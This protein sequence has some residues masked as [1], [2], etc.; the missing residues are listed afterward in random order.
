[1]SAG[2][3]SSPR[4]ARNCRQSVFRRRNLEE[5]PLDLGEKRLGEAFELRRAQP[6]PIANIELQDGLLRNQCDG[7]D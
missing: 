6:D 5:L 7:T 4:P 1:M 3:D 2:L